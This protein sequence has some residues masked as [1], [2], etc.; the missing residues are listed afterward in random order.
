MIKIYFKIILNLN[1]NLKINYHLKNSIKT[2]EIIESISKD[3][4]PYQIKSF[5]SKPHKR[6]DY[7][8]I[9]NELQKNN[10]I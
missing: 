3:Y 2:I 9:T 1:S 10:F 8:Y 5:N 7:D 4:F 6:D